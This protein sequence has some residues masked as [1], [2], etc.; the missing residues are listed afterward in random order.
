MNRVRP[1][2]TSPKVNTRSSSSHSKPSEATLAE[3]PSG[4]STHVARR[5]D[6]KLAF[7]VLVHEVSRIRRKAIDHALKPM[8]ITGGQW[9]IITFISLHHGL[10][11]VALAEE[12]N[13]GKVALGGLVDRLESAGMIER[14]PD[15]NDR[16]MNRIYLSKRGVGLVKDIKRASEGIQARALDGI[17]FEELKHAITALRKMESNLREFVRNP[18]TPLTEKKSR[19]STS[20]RSIYDQ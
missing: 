8:G 5:L 1:K 18:G 16:R 17:T 6:R 2:L 10:S 4:I 11:Q 7:G 12:L 19:K 20:S 13:M 15:G 14:R 9:W 3:T